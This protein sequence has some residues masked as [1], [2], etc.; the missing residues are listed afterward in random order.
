MGPWNIIRNSSV[1]CRIPP[2][3]VF[4]FDMPKLAAASFHSCQATLY[5][6]DY[7]KLGIPQNATKEEIKAAYFGKAKQLHPDSNTRLTIFQTNLN[8]ATKVSW[9]DMSDIKNLN[10]LIL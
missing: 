8:I 5:R 4:W 3:A 2:R 1:V 6:E 9:S 10:Q 7:V